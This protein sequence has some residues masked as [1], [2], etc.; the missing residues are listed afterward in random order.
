MK[1]IFE[2]IKAER[3]KQ[4][5]KWGVQT[6]PCTARQI[7]D[8]GNLTELELCAAHL[9][10][11]EAQAKHQCNSNTE[12]GSITYADIAIEELVESIV[13]PDPKAR[14]IELIQLAAV[15]VGWIESL[16]RTMQNNASE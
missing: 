7:P 6:H 5:V 16:D 12:L 2:E 14:R 13:E 11:T 10:P 1:N 15:C 8:S 9:I 3:A 4:E